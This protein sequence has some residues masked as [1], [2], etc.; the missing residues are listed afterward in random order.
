M[1]F[2]THV[3]FDGESD[4]DIAAMMDRAAAA[5]VLSCLAIGGSVSLNAGALRA[6]GVH[7]RIAG[8]ALG[9]DRGHAEHMAA[10]ELSMEA[11]VSELERLLSGPGVRAVG[12]IGLDFHYTPQTAA[13]QVALLE[14]QLDLAR[15]RALPVVIHSREA[16]EA[17]L[18]TLG[19]HA[20]QWGG[21]PAR[22]GVLHCF[23]GSAPFAR[24]LLDLGYHISFSGIV[25]FRNAQAL[26]EVAALV[27][28]DR[29]LIETDSPYLAPVPYR[30]QPNEPAFVASVAATLATVRGQSIEALAEVTTR[31]AQRLFLS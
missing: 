13:L 28:G 8:V 21:D 31:N 15:R 18:A 23:T 12:E 14:A 22:L 29:L 11:L 7:A 4:G 10:R 3:H 19:W 27:P 17:T 30:G 16:D 24:R 25:T 20:R 1:Y 9:F 26:R 6:Q 5:G 2:D